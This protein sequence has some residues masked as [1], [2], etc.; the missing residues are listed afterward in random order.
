MA[1]SKD[2][3]VEVKSEVVKE[4]V[5]PVEKTYT[6]YA[7]FSLLGKDFNAGDAFPVPFNFKLTD[8]I[9]AVQRKG[10][11]NRGTAFAVDSVTIILPVE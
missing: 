7:P 3:V 11:P 5:K 8:K 9:E 1:K 10:R 6:V 4:E 2:I